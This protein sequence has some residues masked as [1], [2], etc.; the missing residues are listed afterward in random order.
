MPLLD[1]LA[2][3]PRRPLGAHFPTLPPQRCPGQGTP[4]WGAKA[5]GIGRAEAAPADPGSERDLLLPQAGL[6]LAGRGHQ[7]NVGVQLDQEPVLQHPHHH[8]NELG[9]QDRQGELGTGGGWAP[10]LPCS[11]PNRN[12]V[13]WPKTRP[14]QVTLEIQGCTSSRSLT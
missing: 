11:L 6:V 4:T 13:P 8:L 5:E 1:H 12:G 9:L 3:I 10:P 2:T 14:S 7:A